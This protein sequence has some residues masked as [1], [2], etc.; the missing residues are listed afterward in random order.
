[1]FALVFLGVRVFYSLVNLSTQKPYLNPTTGTMPI[2]V[3]LGF[4]PDLIAGIIYVT[5]GL[6]TQGAAS[7]TN[8][9]GDDVSLRHK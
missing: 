8:H 7:M 9:A 4:L 2:R 6:M 3:I 1:M 5:A